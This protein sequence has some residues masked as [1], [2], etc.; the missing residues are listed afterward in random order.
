MVF[1]TRAT[2]G[3]VTEASRAALPATI[4]YPAAPRLD[5]VDD[6][7]GHAVPDP[8]RWLE[9][10]ADPRT[11]AW[12]DEQDGVARSWLDA[13]PGRDALAARLGELMRTGSVGT[14]VWRAGRAFYTRRGPD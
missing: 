13:M 7:H 1:I 2:L 11:A 8:Y 5:L 9:D 4:T 6:L 10:P 12:S 3:E 14:P